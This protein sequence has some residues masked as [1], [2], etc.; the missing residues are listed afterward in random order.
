MQIEFH[1]KALSYAIYFINPDIQL[2]TVPQY[3]YSTQAS[4]ASKTHRHECGTNIWIGEGR[5]VW[6]DVL[7]TPPDFGPQSNGEGVVTRLSLPRPENF[8]SAQSFLTQGFVSNLAAFILKT[9]E[10]VLTPPIK[11]FPLVDSNLIISL[12]HITPRNEK[13]DP[14]FGWKEIQNQL[15][16]LHYFERTIEFSEYRISPTQ[17]HAAVLAYKNAI[18]TSQVKSEIRSVLDPAELQFWLEKSP[19]FQAVTQVQGRVIPIFLFDLK[20]LISLE[21]QPAVAFPNMVVASVGPLKEYFS[22]YSCGGKSLSEDYRENNIDLTRSI[23]ASILQSAWGVAPPYQTWSSIRKEISEDFTYSVGLTPFG[24]FSTAL[25]L[26]FSIKDQVYRALLLQYKNQTFTELNDY[27]TFFKQH[28]VELGQILS[29]NE[30]ETFY[31]RWMSLTEKMTKAS[32]AL[33]FH[34]FKASTNY[35]RSIN[36]DLLAINEILTRN[37]LKLIYRVDCSEAL[38]DEKESF[39]IQFIEMILVAVFFYNAALL[40]KRFTVFGKIKKG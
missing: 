23:L 10:H 6:L 38:E 31:Y 24:P 22:Q 11:W 12:V 28:N 14:P 13:L 40:T 27:L 17:W 26:P 15:R 20:D 16:N 8:K 7:A 25:T 9:C 29:S 5:Y 33:S 37:T 32:E 36:H 21:T 34:S 3:W 35:F 4:K 1:K 39:L 18:R 30:F 2:D 19:L